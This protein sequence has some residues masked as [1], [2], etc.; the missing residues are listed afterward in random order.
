MEK[1]SFA[2]RA[3][4][5]SPLAVCFTD[6]QGTIL[7]ANRGFL[8]L[9]GYGL[10]EVLGKN[11]RIL[12]SGRQRREAYTELWRAI[13]S[14]GQGFWNGEVI[15]RRKDGSEVT[16]H[17][18]VSAVR[19][20][21]GRHVGFSASALDITKRKAMEEEL[22]EKNRELVSLN[23]LKSE[24][25]AITSHDLRSPL[26]ALT[27]R[28]EQLREAL[29]RAGAGHA[30]AAEA[31]AKIAA[32]T[33][34]LSELV[35]SLLDLERMGSQA[36]TLSLRRVF[37]DAVIASSI[38]TLR[39]AF[40]AKGVGLRFEAESRRE[41]VVLDVIKMEQVFGNILGNA[42]RFSPPGTDVTVHLGDGT[43]GGKRIVVS[44]Q[45]P[46][47]PPEDLVRIFDR[48]Y[49]VQKRNGLAERAFGGAGL[50]LAIAR[51]VV[52]SH[53]GRI[54]AENIPGGG[55][56]FVIELP[57]R[58]ATTTG[59]DLAVIIVDPAGVL[60]SELA[61]PLEKKDAEIFTVKSAWELRRVYEYE[62]PE[63]LFF[64]AGTVDGEAAAF[65]RQIRSE[66][67]CPTLVIAVEEE[68]GQAIQ[69]LG[70]TAL[71]TLPVLETEIFE[72]L[73]SAA[74]SHGER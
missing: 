53:E 4:L 19:D 47:V 15:N 61:P 46:G 69:T 42:L 6:R 30:Q 14:P 11:P 8:D 34:Q 45:G 71:L 1:L 13:C 21:A 66:P 24:L 73:F 41:R 56:R 64:D 55:A 44:D 20:A 51:S 39:P 2:Y 31:L 12:K 5:T 28:A 33:R 67:V 50:G 54:F 25:M 62:R 18:T 74:R 23:R 26:H 3:F 63:L 17:L 35:Q 16:V 72:I 48:Y 36:M 65:I 43:D 7:D 10:D 52:E 70:A 9:Y 40:D 29:P 27:L 22:A 60:A 57:R 49:Q 58:T 68:A 32:S 59:R 37:L 38:E